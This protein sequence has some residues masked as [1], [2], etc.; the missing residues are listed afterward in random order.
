MQVPEY[1]KRQDELK[2]KGVD[3]MVVYCVNDGAV[4]KG[5]AKEQGVEG[6]LIT[7]MADP[8][9][10]LT[11]K[12]GMMMR[13]PGPMALLGNPR[14]KRFVLV[15]DNL[16]VKAVEVSEAEGDPAGDNEPQGPVTALTRIDH[17]LTLL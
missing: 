11:R 1:L 6:S 17:V 4:M 5:W 3:E 9:C 13:H 10:K 16:E 12:L 2:A 8:Q 15:L 7:F 14:C